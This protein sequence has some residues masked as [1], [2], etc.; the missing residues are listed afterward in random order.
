VSPLVISDLYFEHFMIIFTIVAIAACPLNVI[1][2]AF[3]GV[4]ETSRNVTDTS[5]VTLK[6]IYNRNMFMVQATELVACII[7]IF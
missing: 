4:N 6:I 7:K 1:E 2:D 3:M 5:R